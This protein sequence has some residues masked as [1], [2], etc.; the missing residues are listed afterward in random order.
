MPRAECCPVEEVW[1]LMLCYGGWSRLACEFLRGRLLS[2]GECQDIECTMV[3]LRPSTVVTGLKKA[4]KIP[5]S[6]VGW[7][8]VGSGD[9]KT[10]K[11]EILTNC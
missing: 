4:P 1:P 3:A 9:C 6:Y 10:I 11:E 2:R 7:G 5:Q 8:K